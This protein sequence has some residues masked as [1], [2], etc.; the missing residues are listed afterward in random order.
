[1]IINNICTICPFKNFVRRH[2]YA[3]IH[4]HTY[5]HKRWQVVSIS[6]AYVQI[7][8]RSDLTQARKA[9]K[10]NSSHNFGNVKSEADV[11]KQE[12]DIMSD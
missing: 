1:M 7:Y 12:A 8:E 3:H 10:D 9:Q 2:F 6:E 11:V 4:T 5:I